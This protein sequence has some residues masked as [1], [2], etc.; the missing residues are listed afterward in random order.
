VVHL[1]EVPNCGCRLRSGFGRDRTVR[2]K[3]DCEQDLALQVDAI[4]LDGESVLLIHVLVYCAGQL[5]PQ[6]WN[7]PVSSIS[8]AP[9]E[10]QRRDRGE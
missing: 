6:I 10:R 5:H 8:E 1:L 2:G 4:L 9:S 3:L 7:N